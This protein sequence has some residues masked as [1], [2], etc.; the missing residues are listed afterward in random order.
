VRFDS[1]IGSVVDN[2][3]IVAAKAVVQSYCPAV[4]FVVRIRG[5]QVEVALRPLAGRSETV[6][7]LVVS[8]FDGRFVEAVVGIGSSAGD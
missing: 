5:V 8:V 3:S 6:E 2:L 4:G 1:E 7:V